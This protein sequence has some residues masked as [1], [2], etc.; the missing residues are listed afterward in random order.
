MPAY[1]IGVVLTAS[2]QGV[3]PEEITLLLVSSQPERLETW[4]TYL[5]S[6]GMVVRAAAPERQ[7]V[8]SACSRSPEVVVL[9]LETAVIDLRQLRQLLHSAYPGQTPGVIV[10]T[11]PK[12]IPSLIREEV[13]DLIP[14][15]ATPEEV[16]F[17]VRRLAERLRKEPAPI[18]VG[19]LI[20]GPSEG[21]VVVDGTPLSLCRREYELL[22]F[23]ASHPDRVFRRSQLLWPIWGP[24]FQG[25]RRTVDVLVA[26]L[27]RRL[28]SFGQRQLQTVRGVGYRLSSAPMREVWD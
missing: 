18:Q 10:A 8:S 5:A 25:S 21:Q 7:A 6:N 16:H 27:R 22:K 23:L 12:V 4:S 2:T 9:D 1:S 15:S 11:P 19:E 14:L 20:L 28:G 24:E 13:H 3:K 26:R 17:R